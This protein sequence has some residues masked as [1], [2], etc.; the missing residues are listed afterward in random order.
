MQ[1]ASTNP[2]SLLAPLGGNPGSAMMFASVGERKLPHLALHTFPTDTVCRCGT[3]DTPGTTGRG[4]NS[5]IQVSR[6]Q[7]HRSSQDLAFAKT[8]EFQ[9]RIGHRRTCPGGAMTG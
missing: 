9:V 7:R 3:T 1:Q 4:Q 5:K 2:A 8:I 6:S